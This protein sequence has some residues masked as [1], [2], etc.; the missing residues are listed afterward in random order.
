[1]NNANKMV[2][3]NMPL[4][5]HA[6]FHIQYFLELHILISSSRKSICQTRS[7]LDYEWTSVCQTGMLVAV[8]STAAQSANSV[9]RDRLEL[10]QVCVVLCA[11]FLV[12][13]KIFLGQL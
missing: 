10:N 3:L 8:N 7:D 1:M 13:Y 11:P 6:R 4:A 2:K 12:F 5:T 9:Q